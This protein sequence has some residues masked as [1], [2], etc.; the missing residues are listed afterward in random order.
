MKPV[1][2]ISFRFIQPFPLFHGRKETGDSEWPP[3]PL[4]AFQA[5]VNAACLLER[6]KSLPPEIQQVLQALEM[7][8]PEIMVPEGEPTTVGHRAYVPHNHMDLVT[9]AWHRGDVE[10]NIA[11]H[12]VEKDYRPIRMEAPDQSLPVLHYL[13]SLE[14]VD[15]N[16]VDLLNAIRPIARAVTHLGWGIDQVAG[17]A[18]LVDQAE[19][20]LTG[21]RW[22]PA[23]QTGRRL[24]TPRNGTLSALTRRYGQFLNRLHEGWTSVSPLTDDDVAQARYRPENSPRPRPFAVFRLV[25]ENDDTVAYPQ[26]QIIHLAGMVRHLAIRL[27]KQNPPIDLRGWSVEEWLDEYVAGHQNPEKSAVNLPHQ[28]FSYVPLPSIGHYHADPAIR[29]IMIIAPTGDEAWLSSLARRL[30]EQLLQPDE[31]TKLPRGTRLQLIAE[32]QHDGVRDLYCDVSRTWASVTPVILPGYDDHRPAKTRRLIEKALLQSGI[33]QKCEYEWSPFPYFPKSL[34]AH[35]YGRDKQL[36]GY[37]RPDHLL[38]Q[39][40]VHLKLFFQDQAIISGPLTIG[41]GR[42]CGFGLMAGVRNF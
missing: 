38:N 17:D 14:S 34:T 29:R 6:G 33:D 24:R 16:P 36:S 23:D 41:A 8:Q 7:V 42:H 10:A 26:R 40:A 20:S 19:E 18:I 39:T 32:R 4:R 35:K 30:Q 5:I 37:I 22:L 27:M 3:S 2:C 13:Y 31:R 21:T 9:A 28:Q 15:L 1:L 11:G 25:D 12:R